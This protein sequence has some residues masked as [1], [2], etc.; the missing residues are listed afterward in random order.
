MLELVATI[1]I[2]IS[3]EV[4]KISLKLENLQM[5]DVNKLMDGGVY[6]IALN[7]IPLYVGETYNFYMRFSKHLVEL[8]N[9][10]DYFGLSKLEGKYSLGFYIIKDKLPYKPI[11]LD[12]NKRRTDENKKERTDWEKIYINEYRPMTQRL[13]QGCNIQYTSNKKYD[14]MIRDGNEKSKIVNEVIEGSVN[15]IYCYDENSQIYKPSIF[16]DIK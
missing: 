10:S 15:R 14:G 3:K 12:V 2:N 5:Q 1:E 13:P 16:N 6:L 11:K 7:K 8:D 9:D 4:K